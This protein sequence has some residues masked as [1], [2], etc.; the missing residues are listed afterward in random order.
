MAVD[1]GTSFIKCC[2]DDTES[3]CVEEAMEPV[4]DERPSPGVFIQRGDDLFASVV[5]CIKVVSE[6]LGERA[7]DIAAIAFT[8]QM[9]GF[10]GGEGLG[11]YYHMVLFPGFP[12]YAICKKA[13]GGTER[14]VFGNQRDEF[15]ADGTQI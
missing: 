1:L 7:Q 11:G 3:I 12:V 2:V 15:S 10:M 8:G 4:K 5:N 14:R 13:D 6:K 9:S